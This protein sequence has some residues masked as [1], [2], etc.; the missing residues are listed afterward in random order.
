MDI[1]FS[2]RQEERV[3]MEPGV[4]AFASHIFWLGTSGAN[5]W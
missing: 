1:V 3:L 4:E 2:L 5:T